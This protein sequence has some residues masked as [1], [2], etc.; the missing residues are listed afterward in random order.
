MSEVWGVPGYPETNIKIPIKYADVIRMNI[1]YVKEKLISEFV[2]DLN[3]IPNWNTKK[4]NFTV[5]YNDINKLIEKWEEKL[6]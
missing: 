6:K 5:N 1:S 2:E 4:N 3:E